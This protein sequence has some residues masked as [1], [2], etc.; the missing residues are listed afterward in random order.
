MHDP[1]PESGGRRLRIGAV[2]YLNSKPLVESLAELAPHADLRLDFPSR[3]ADQLRQGAIDVGLVPSVATLLNPGYEIVSD[4]CVATRGPVLSVKMYSRVPAGQI[5]R[6]SLDEGSRTSAML[7]RILLAER[8]GIFPA[9]EKLPL[10]CSLE[11]SSADAI[12]LIGDRAILPPAESFEVT[13]DLG[14][15]WTRMTGLPFVFALWASR[16]GEDLQ[17]LEDALCN[18]RDL[19]VERLE[20]IARREAPLLGLSEQLTLDYL[21]DNL[22]YHLGEAERRG[23]ARF[24][25]LAVKYDL[26]PGGIPLVF[27]HFAAA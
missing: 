4:A 16:R 2:T 12:L 5:R 6:L 18:A 1:Q 26:V 13:W 27:R 17:G 19:G 25:Q 20:A 3:L 9:I 14:E 22:Y 21:R 15:E 7:V 23:L 24:Q 11:S 10:D 8:H